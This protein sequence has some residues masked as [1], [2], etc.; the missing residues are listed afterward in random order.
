[1]LN[2]LGKAKINSINV[3]KAIKTLLVEFINANPEKLYIADKN[4]LLNNTL[5]EKAFL[6]KLIDIYCKYSSREY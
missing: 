5:L 4:K 1:M 2:K 6:A 3:S